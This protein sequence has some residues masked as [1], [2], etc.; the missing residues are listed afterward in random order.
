MS[1]YFQTI[2]KSS[3]YNSPPNYPQLFLWIKKLKGSLVSKFSVYFNEL[4]AKNST[5]SFDMKSYCSKLPVDYYGRMLSFQK[6]SDAVSVCI[7]FDSKDTKYNPNGYS[8]VGR[9]FVVPQGLESFPAVLS[10]PL[11]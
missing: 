2:K 10:I 9:E 4:L 1:L 7:I 6:K 3:F 8:S 5:P 11:V